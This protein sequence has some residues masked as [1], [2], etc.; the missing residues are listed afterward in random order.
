[1]LIDRRPGQ[2]YLLLLL[3]KWWAGR[4]VTGTRRHERHRTDEIRDSVGKISGKKKN[5]NNRVINTLVDPPRVMLL[6]F[7]I[8]DDDNVS[9]GRRMFGRTAGG[10]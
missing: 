10:W 7:I 8:D 1:M 2:I 6:L 5:N 3:G 9:P 4:R